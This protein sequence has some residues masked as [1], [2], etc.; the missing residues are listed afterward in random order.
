[1]S[2]GKTSYDENVSVFTKEDVKL[3]KEEDVMITCKGK[4]IL[5]GKR[6]ERGRYR[7]PL[8]QQK[9]KWQP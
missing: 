2:V 6:D 4:T 5:V 7:I 8:I 1:M 3:Y 9:G